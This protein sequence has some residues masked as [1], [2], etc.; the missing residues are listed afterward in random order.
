MRTHKPHNLSCAEILCFWRPSATVY[1]IPGLQE[2][3]PGSPGPRHCDR[4][5]SPHWA[6]LVALSRGWT[7][8]RLEDS[9]LFQLPV[10]W[11]E[12]GKQIVGPWSFPI[13]NFAG[14]RHHSNCFPHVTQKRSN[15]TKNAHDN[16]LNKIFF[17]LAHLLIFHLATISTKL[18]I[19]NIFV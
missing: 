1:I 10:S 15:W 19:Y 12:V 17:T 7:G 6:V 3:V 13:W 2:S 9:S 11:Q 5:I 18:Y 8:Q 14:Q 16:Y 4:D